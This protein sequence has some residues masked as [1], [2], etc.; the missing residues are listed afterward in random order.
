ML[1]SLYL[2]K[3]YYMTFSSCSLFFITIA[4][5]LYS[6]KLLKTAKDSTLGKLIEKEGLD[7]GLVQLV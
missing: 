3:F 1:L 4:E 5:S 7:S 6:I 2:I